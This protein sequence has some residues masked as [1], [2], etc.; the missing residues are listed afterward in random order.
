MRWDRPTGPPRRI[1]RRIPPRR[2][3][4]QPRLVRAHLG[5]FLTRKLLRTDHGALLRREFLLCVH[6]SSA[7]PLFASGGTTGCW[8]LSAGRGS[9]A[10]APNP[11]M[12]SW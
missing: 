10:F 11:K 1:P 9:P 12:F 5:L 2:S 7:V 3:I 6:H 8:L 4:G